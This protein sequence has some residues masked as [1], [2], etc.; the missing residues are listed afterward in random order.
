MNY[1]EKCS[2]AVKELEAAKIWKFNYNPPITRLI[3]RLG[4][5]VPFP[6]YNYFLKNALSMGIYFSFGWGLL[7]Y[8]FV[9]NT[10]NISSASMLLTAIFAGAF[11]GVAMASYY[12]YG[13]KKYKL[14]PWHEIKSS[15]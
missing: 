2:F 3:R 1:E 5:E 4:F 15:Q 14:T 9:W 13:F 8:F 10:K 6:H 11:F 12:S 7:M